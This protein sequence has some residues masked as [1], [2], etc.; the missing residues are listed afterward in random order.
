M[1]KKEY[2][3]ESVDSL[4]NFYFDCKVEINSKFILIKSTKNEISIYD[5]N[6]N[7][8]LNESIKEKDII[9]FFEFHCYYETIFFVGVNRN[10]K[11][12]EIDEEKQKINKLS[13]IKGYFK[14][15]YFVSSSPFN[16]NIFL[17]VSNKNNI[18]IYDITSALPLN[19]ILLD[20][21]VNRK[22]KWGK[23]HIGFRKNN[24][25][26]Y[27]NYINF[28]KE[29]TKR[30]TLENIKDFFFNN[31]DELI[32]I[33]YNNNIIIA[34]NNEV[35]LNKKINSNKEID[36]I[37]YNVINNIMMIIEMDE[38]IGIKFDINYNFSELI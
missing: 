10:I 29:Y 4:R 8:F 22:I 15:I 9:L 25:I 7:S 38:I 17:S 24:T 30:F 16:P 35:V 1:I 11:I 26:I 36:L 2:D 34:K 37:G 32:I 6:K 20:E 33:Q 14:D 13:I 5:Y 12:Y 19:H 28:E 3:V 23:N 27:L 21:K 18:K 31:N